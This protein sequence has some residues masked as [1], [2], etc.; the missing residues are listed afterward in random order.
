MQ[1]NIKLS[2]AQL[3]RRWCHVEV[4]DG[5]KVHKDLVA[6]VESTLIPGTGL[7][8][9][10][11]WAGLGEIC[12]TMSGKNKSLLDARDKTQALID[13][14]H[15][16]RKGQ[17]LNHE[18]YK[19]FLT[20]IGYLV[21]RSADFQIQTQ[22]VDPE[23]SSIPAPQL[24]CPV[25]N[26]R[27][28]VNAANARWGSL[29]DALYG[30]DVIP[31][32]IPAGGYSHERG[33]LV[34]AELHN[35]LDKIFPIAGQSWADITE[36]SV[37]DGKLNLPLETPSA[38]TGYTEKDGAISV[39]L[40]NNGLHME[41]LVNKA[42]PVGKSHKAGIYDVQVEAALSV[43]ADAEDS[44]C[45][46]DVADKI[47]AYTNWTGLMDQTL[48]IPVVK[49]G[50]VFER[51]LNTPKKFTTP[52]GGEIELS[53]RA[54]LMCRNVG[55]HMYTDIVKTNGDETP[56]QFLDAVITTLAGVHDLKGKSNSK[57]G[58]VYLVKPK[59]HGPEEVKFVDELFTK[60]EEVLKIPKNTVK[61]GIMDEERRM[62]VNLR[63]ALSAARDRVFFINTGFLDR[64]ADEIHTSMEAGPMLP[65]EEI[66]HVEWI[67]AYEASN[68]DRG[69][70]QGLKG[71]GQIGKGMW[72]APDNMAEMMEKKIGHLQVGA[73]TAWVPS[74]TAA[75]LH[76]LHYHYHDVLNTQEELKSNVADRTDSILKPPVL[77]RELTQ[78]EIQDELDC[79]VQSLLGY[80]VRWVGLGVGCSKV[81]DTHD[82][83]LM[84]DRAT[85]RISSQHI[86]NWHHHG[87]ISEEQI[88]ETMKKMAVIVDKQ[89]AHDPEYPPMA[90]SYDTVE[91][92]AARDLIFKGTTTANGYTEGVLSSR[93]REKKQLLKAS[94]A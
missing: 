91:F 30:T 29:L 55:L 80:V 61:I 33:A 18:E 2:L 7:E 94:S 14:Y 84:E 82:V 87:L 73:T 64:V 52:S 92:H 35:I 25:D 6:F 70:E 85:L 66:R 57:G 62:S 19:A 53:G 23:M 49:N 51:R 67:K 77:D 1:R 56:E 37:K 39:L 43:L 47:V 50:K 21:P 26:A 71:K 74:P 68:V 42:H 44:A 32:A 90:P 22:N 28:I 48:H 75:T 4:H 63:E 69:L 81:P 38:F 93:R 15:K 65:K 41:V 78:K 83:Q 40:K 54:V 59:M 12:L 11:V 3:G 34:F 89:N 9:K 72:A 16:E 10:E 60:V 86:A 31:G 58:S 79:N 46:V 36:V 45:T 27:Y 5:V 8:N 24:V 13:Q 20:E 76:A 88:L 17:P